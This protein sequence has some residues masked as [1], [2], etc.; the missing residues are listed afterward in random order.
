VQLNS[1][2]DAMV[3]VV[4]DRIARWT[5]LPHSHGE[6]LQVSKVCQV[7]CTAR[8]PKQ[9]CSQDCPWLHWR[10]A[11]GSRLCLTAAAAAAGGAG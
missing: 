8:L 11:A 9:E 3:G 5:L 2:A 4:D 10:T 1:S 6:L 7:A